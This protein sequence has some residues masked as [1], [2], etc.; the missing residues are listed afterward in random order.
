[1]VGRSKERNSLQNLTEI[2]CLPPPRD[3]KDLR[4]CMSSESVSPQFDRQIPRTTPSASVP[5]MG[6]VAS[7]RS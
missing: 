3:A 2:A 6:Y 4:L 1:M 5:G 7:L